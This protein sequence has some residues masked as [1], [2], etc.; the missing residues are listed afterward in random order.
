MVVHLPFLGAGLSFR[1]ELKADI[2]ANSECFDLLELIADQ[3]I[4]KPS[5]RTA[6]A[7][8]L[9]KQF[10]L[11]LHGV[12]L[13]IGTDCP[14]D[15]DYLKKM[16]DVADLIDAKWVSDHLSFTR[17][18]GNRLGQ[19]TPLPFTD[20][21]IKTVVAHVKEIK[22][23]VGRPFLLENISYYFVVP[24]SS[25]SEATF[26]SRV[27]TESDCFL[28]LDLTNLLNNS[29]NNAYDPIDFLEQ[30]PLDRVVQIH[31]AGSTQVRK[32]WID[33]HSRP[34]PEGVFHLL[35]YAV[36]KM[37]LL[38]GIIIER[39]QD[40][41]SIDEITSDL[42]RVRQILKRNW[43]PTYLPQSDNQASEHHTKSVLSTSP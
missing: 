14:L 30:I 23:L 37:P 40:F 33:S 39:D 42:S 9:A 26:L 8:E 29:M 24:E 43:I 6:E 22:N 25:M 5:F 38:R 12:D 13:S 15:T 32:M 7:S 18:P 11:I 20:G 21:M 35:E 27:V 4:D 10:P 3:Y 2:L 36:P 41:P 31:L 17:I 19:L 34:V 16:C 1:K 28:L